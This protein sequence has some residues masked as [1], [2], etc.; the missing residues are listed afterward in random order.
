MNGPERRGWEE[1]MWNEY[2]NLT[3]HEAFEPVPEDT[4]PTWDAIKGRAS[5]VVS[6]L[7]VLKKKYVDDVFEK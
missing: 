5:E 2:S 7:T 6:L 3:S 1:A 4:L